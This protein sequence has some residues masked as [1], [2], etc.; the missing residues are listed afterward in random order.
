MTRHI[1]FL[2]SGSGLL[3][4]ASLLEEDAPQSTE[5]VWRLAQHRPT[6]DAIHAIWTGPELS[7]PLPQSVLPDALQQATVPPENA[8]S[9]PEAGDIVLAFIAAG[10]VEGLPPGNFF[11]V[12]IF[13]EPGGRLLMPF[14]WIKG[15][16]CARIIPDDLAQTRDCINAI[17]QNGACRLT[18][19]TA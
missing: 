1:R 13:Y 3:A 19:E 6:F 12:G 4:R 16:V 5:F 9:H 10:T 2:E 17:R 18:I 7:C 8:T 11:D 15:N 14:G